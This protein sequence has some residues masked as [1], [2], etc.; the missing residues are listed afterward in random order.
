MM[1]RR[2][3]KTEYPKM[4]ALQY[5]TWRT[6]VECKKNAE[7]ELKLEE[8]RCALRT[9]NAEKIQLQN[10]LL[11]KRRLDLKQKFEN[12]SKVYDE[13]ILNLSSELKVDIDGKSIN[14][15]TYEIVDDD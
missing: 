1:A 9:V 8:A 2:I 13:F 12:V 10:Q 3:K 14:P 5:Y 4:S 7:L 6:N 15:I 11:G